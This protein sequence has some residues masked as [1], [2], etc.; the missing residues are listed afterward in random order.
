MAR[1]PRQSAPLGPAVVQGARMIEGSHVNHA[2]AMHF[3][4]EHFCTAGSPSCLCLSV[5]SPQPGKGSHLPAAFSELRGRNKK[6]LETQGRKTPSRHAMGYG[7]QTVSSAAYISSPVFI[8]P[9]HGCAMGGSPLW[10]SH[11]GG[12]TWGW[13]SCAFLQDGGGSGLPTRFRGPL[14]ERQS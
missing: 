12:R 14:Q 2:R 10:V 6:A 9:Q 8:L 1:V 11:P 13:Q 7:V 3:K 5:P 4:A